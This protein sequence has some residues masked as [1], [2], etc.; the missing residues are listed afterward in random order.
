MQ[1]KDDQTYFQ[2]TIYR[3]CVFGGH[4]IFEISLHH[5]GS[6]DPKLTRGSWCNV[7]FMVVH[8]PSFHV[9]LETA[10]CPRLHKSPLRGD[11]VGAWTCFG[12]A[13]GLANSDCSSWAG[14]P[15][16]FNMT[17]VDQYQPSLRPERRR[18]EV[19]PS[20]RDLL[21]GAEPQRMFFRED[22]S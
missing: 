8:Q 18:R 5:I 20:I 9:G 14:Q 6:P 2:P 13:V 11:N 16:K 4:R 12:Q 17:L 7:L 22:R 10:D 19:E 1:L 3:D 21:A 15:C